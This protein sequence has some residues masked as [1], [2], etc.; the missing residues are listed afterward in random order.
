MKLTTATV[1][2]LLKKLKLKQMAQILETELEEGLRENRDTLEILG[3][4]LHEQVRVNDEARINRYL[5]MARFPD[6]KT[7]DSFDWDFQPTIDRHRV[8]HLARLDFIDRR[9]NVLLE[10][11]PGTGRAT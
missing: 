11:D 10:G 4:I 2:E 6:R 1:L 5:K 8:M 7:L 3:R 9:E